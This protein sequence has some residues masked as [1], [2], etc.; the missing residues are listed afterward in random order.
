VDVSEVDAS[1]R[2][3]V[4]FQETF[5]NRLKGISVEVKLDAVNAENALT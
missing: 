5:D 1:N 4:T 3:I 2:R